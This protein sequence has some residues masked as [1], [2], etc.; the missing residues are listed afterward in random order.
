MI[1]VLITAVF[2]LALAFVLGTALGFFKDFFDVPLDPLVGRIRDALPGANCGACGF[3]GCENFA[4][5]V[6]DGTAEL[7]ACSVGG[8]ALVAKLSEI[9]GKAGAASVPIVAVLACQGSADHAPLKGVYTGIAT[10]RGAKL[11]AGGTKVC[12]WGCLGF[13]DCV[14]VCKFDAIHMDAQLG[15]PIVQY[16]KCT[17]CKVCIK[18]CPQNILRTVPLDQTGAI[19]LCANVNTNKPAATKSCKV[20]CNKCN[21]CVKNC[22]LQCIDLSS[23]IPVID[24]AQ[25]DSCG[26]C[27]EKCPRKVIKIIEKDLFTSPQVA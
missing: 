7:N 17:G 23:G 10:C 22:P 25:C 14:K 21:L 1:I 24:Y 2:A 13:G 19:A 5:A 15:L 3:P 20:S 12:D 18:E 9:T 6:A 16:A 4:I 26:T 8:A 11:S 27:V